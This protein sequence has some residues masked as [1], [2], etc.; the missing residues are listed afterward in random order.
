MD[1][2]WVP[3]NREHNVSF[4]FH[5]GQDAL[6][7][8]LVD[9]CRVRGWHS[10]RDGDSTPPS[11]AAT[12]IANF[13]TDRLPIQVTRYHPT[14]KGSR[15]GRSKVELRLHSGR[16]I[17]ETNPATVKLFERILLLALLLLDSAGIHAPK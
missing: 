9:R 16:S 17:Q 13:F 11:L 10:D 6:L 3:P 4:G 14:T 15:D 7:L 1:D 12:V 5:L 2:V 8:D